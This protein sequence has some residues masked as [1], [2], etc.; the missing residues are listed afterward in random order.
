MINKSTFTFLKGIKKHND[1]E[2]FEENKAVYKTARAEFVELLNAFAL[3]IATF[4]PA[5]AKAV[6]QDKEVV[7]TFRIYRDVRFSN[8]KTKYKTNLSGY[9]SADVKNPDE[10]VYYL[11]VQPGESS[12]FG[13]GLYSPERMMLN[14]IRD[15]IEAHPKA[16]FKVEKNAEFK[17]YFAIN[18]TGG[19]KTA[20]RGY[21]AEHEAIEYL[22][23]K[24]LT[25]HMEVSDKQLKNPKM[26]QE[27][28]KPAKALHPLIHFIRQ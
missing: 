18:R 2:W 25:A 19:L 13:G 20:P 21:D 11:S 3:D 16:L 17:K 26:L 5:V 10:P 8:N 9:V 6:K 12:F 14:A 15:K 1:K 4:D 23:L 7:K 27:L 24:G 28:A 22:R